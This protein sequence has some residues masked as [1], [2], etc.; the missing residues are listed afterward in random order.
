MSAM[1]VRWSAGW[2]ALDN[3]K[4]PSREDTALVLG[5]FHVAV[6]TKLLRNLQ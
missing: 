6:G 2:D 5:C 3:D 1:G 4:T